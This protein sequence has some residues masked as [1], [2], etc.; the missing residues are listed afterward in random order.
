MSDA[1]TPLQHQGY[2]SKDPATLREEARAHLAKTP[3]RQL[4][5]EL[6]LRLRE[7]RLPWWTPEHLRSRFPGRARMEWLSER[8]EVR[9]QITS[10]LS[11]LAPN[12]A[13]KKTPG[14]QGELI[15]SVIDDGDI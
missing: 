12:A 14:F 2:E 7:L 3:N 15:D 8:I 4:M 10:S 5:A 9:Q 13:R 6:L 11:G 1:P